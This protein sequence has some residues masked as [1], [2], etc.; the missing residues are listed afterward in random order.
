MERE[1]KLLA[2]VSH[3]NIAAIHSLE[4]TDGVKFPVLELVEGQ[5]LEER[6]HS[7]RRMGVEEA[8][9]TARQIALALE[10]AHQHG[11]IHRDLKPANIKLTP[12]GQVKVLDFGLAKALEVSV[13][14]DEAAE[15]PTESITIKGTCRGAIVGT[16]A[17]MSP[18]QA[19]GEPVDKRTD[20]WAFGVVLYEM[21]TGQKVFVGEDLS[22]TLAAILR[23]EPD[24]NLLP[25]GMP[26]LAQSLLRR[27]LRKD[28]DR[29]LHDIADARIEI[30]DSLSGDTEAM[31][32]M[33]AA[34]AAVEATRGHSVEAGCRHRPS[35]GSSS[36]DHDS[37]AARVADP[38]PLDRLSTRNYFPEHSSSGGC[39]LTR[40]QVGGIQRQPAA[41]AP[42]D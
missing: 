14:G 35:G 20:I 23:D 11:I 7:G 41:L 1:A 18:E 6:L 38:P 10:A 12:E 34:P 31:S 4:E 27:C 21:L 29:R 8:L 17:Y 15:A 9:E 37:V 13:F 3:P 22:D 40:W 16:V 26:P 25:P 42:S 19:R 36:L 33:L 39:D 5:T 2:S 28:P 30:E 32:A 24:W